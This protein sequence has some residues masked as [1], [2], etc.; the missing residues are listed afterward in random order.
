MD[1]RVL[2]IVASRIVYKTLP[3]IMMIS[4]A[5]CEYQFA[6]PYINLG[7]SHNEIERDYIGPQTLLD[8]EQI[9]T[10]V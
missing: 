2:H 4:N 5:E 8:K 6:P 7:R 1:L 9:T 10:H 3:E